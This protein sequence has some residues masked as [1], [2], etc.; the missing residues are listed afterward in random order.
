[1]CVIKKQSEIYCVERAT[2]GASAFQYRTAQKS[3]T[4]YEFIQHT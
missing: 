3:H 4:I 1:M 2:Y